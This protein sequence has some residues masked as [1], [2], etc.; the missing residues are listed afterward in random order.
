MSK[1]MALPLLGLGALSALAHPPWS[2]IWTMFIGFV[3]L[4]WALESARQTRRPFWAGVWRAGA[5]G[6]GYFFVSVIWVRHAFYVEADRFGD[7][8]WIAVL[9]LALVLASFWAVAGGVATRLA[10]LPSA[11]PF[12]YAAV[13]TLAEWGRSVLFTGFPWNMPGAIW[14]PGQAISQMAALFG[15]LGLTGLTF[16]LAFALQVALRPRK[17]RSVAPFVVAL[18]IFVASGLWGVQR[19]ATEAPAHDITLRFVQANVTQGDKWRP[20]HRAQILADHL[21]LSRTDDNTPA[22]ILVWPEAAI[23]TALLDDTSAQ[24][25][26]AQHLSE[27]QILVVGSYRVK[28]QDSGNQYYNSLLVFEV[29]GDDLR[30]LKTYDKHHLVPFGEYLPFEDIFSRLGL[31][32]LVSVGDSFSPGAQPTPIKIPVGNDTVTLFPLI[33]Y[34]ALFPQAMRGAR[35]ADLLVNVSNDAWFG[36]DIGPHQHLNQARFRAIETGVPMVR[37]TPTGISAYITA[38]GQVADENRL[39]PGAFGYRDVK[40]TGRKSTLFAENWKHRIV[41]IAILVGLLFSLRS[42]EKLSI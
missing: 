39:N 6:Y 33:C 32:K 21:A 5:F 30:L 23:P 16:F 41:F 13:F 17:G 18:S 11:Q 10:R 35:E 14:H 22:D 31:K 3:A 7:L 20:E 8:A 40:I 9:L 25:A 4:A 2:Q 26:I 37:A 27:G 38:Q 19:L 42:E 15:L 29:T 1:W 24:A 36:H 28:R 34:E 12:V